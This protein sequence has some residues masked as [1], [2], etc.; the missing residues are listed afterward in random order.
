MKR[1][2][3][4]AAGHDVLRY[5]TLNKKYE[6]MDISHR[7]HVDRSNLDRNKLQNEVTKLRTKYARLSTKSEIYDMIEMEEI[8]VKYQKI[9]QE[10]HDLLSKNARLSEEIKRKEREW[11]VRYQKETKRCE[12][13]VGQVKWLSEQV[14][15]T[16]HYYSDNSS[17]RLHVFGPA[18]R[19][20]DDDWG[21]RTGSKKCVNN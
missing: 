15:V 4:D 11:E 14:S 20:T 6:S 10:V 3:S 13:L 19:G 7:Q 21:H 16:P 17:E 9:S 1:T 12:G 5:E 8:R 2:A 18:G